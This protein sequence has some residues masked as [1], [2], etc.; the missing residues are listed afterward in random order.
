MR[1]CCCYCPIWWQTKRKTKRQSEG[2]S[3]LIAERQTNNQRR[4]TKISGGGRTRE[5]V[6]D[7]T[8]KFSPGSK[9]PLFSPYYYS[10]K[11]PSLLLL[12][13]FSPPF[14]SHHINFWDCWWPLFGDA[15][16]N[17]ILLLPSVQLWRF[18]FFEMIGL[19]VMRDLDHLI[20]RRRVR[21][22]TGGVA[23]LSL[24]YR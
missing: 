23:R 20:P 19:I 10:S 7:G 4:Q 24:F 15:N 2:G 8:N 13:S 9:G 6:A 5:E 16:N 14:H 12:F 17:H 1:E 22:G 11:I 21:Y 3:V 18:N